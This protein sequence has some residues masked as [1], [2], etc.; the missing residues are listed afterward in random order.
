[1]ARLRQRL[2]EIGIGAVHSVA[3]KH[4]AADSIS[5]PRAAREDQTLKGDYLPV[6][7][8]ELTIGDHS[9]IGITKE[10]T[11]L[12]DEALTGVAAQLDEDNGAETEQKVLTLPTFCSITV[13][14]YRNGP[15]RS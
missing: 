12:P 6:A 11:I 10:K 14:V 8:I 13:C 7:R 9:H 1:M 3:I 5:R 15:W 4:Q 2:F